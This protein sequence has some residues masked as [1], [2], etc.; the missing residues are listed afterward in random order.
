MGA[1]SCAGSEGRGCGVSLVAANS[2]GTL[3]AMGYGC[4]GCGGLGVGVC[5]VGVGGVGG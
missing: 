3:L 5:C 4:V 2:V 1:D